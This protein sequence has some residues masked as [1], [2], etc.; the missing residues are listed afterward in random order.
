VP[1]VTDL[2]L[3]VGEGELVGLVGH[4][5]AG[6]TTT[7]FAITGVLPIAKGDIRF[8]GVSIRGKKPESILRRGIALVPENRDIFTRLTVEE[9][10]R[11]GASA[12]KDKVE[13]RADIERIVADF[14][15]LRQYF[16]SSAGSLSG[17]EQQ[18]LAIARAL[19]ARPR[20]LLLDEP[21]LG[22]APLLV[23]RVFDILASLREQGTT[24]LLVEQNVRRTVELATRTYIM[25]SGGRI[26]FHGTA[27]DLSAIDN[28]EESYLGIRATAERGAT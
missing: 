16:T 15:I 13:I 12:R 23:D 27:A 1:V 24:M 20:L 2:S 9:N 6:K 10:L 7:L 3:E 14:P 17:G 5:G 22:L 19:L 11:I 18:Q 25:R 26:A 28:F 8:D 4:N 21:S